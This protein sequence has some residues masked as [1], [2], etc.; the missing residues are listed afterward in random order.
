MSKIQEAVQ[1]FEASLSINQQISYELGKAS[2]LQGLGLCYLKLKNYEKAINYFERSLF[3]CLTIK[4]LNG[5]IA[6]HHS[7]ASAYFEKGEYEITVKEILTYIGLSVEL[8]KSYDPG[9]ILLSNV[10][11]RIGLNEYKRTLHLTYSEISTRLRKYIDL[12]LLEF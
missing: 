8:G 5:V 10:R 6:N 3:I 1:K 2:D 4:Y 9:I 7:L 11:E 12:T